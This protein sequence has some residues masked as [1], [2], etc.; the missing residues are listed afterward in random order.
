MS[1][2]SLFGGTHNGQTLS[3][4]SLAL[5]D[6]FLTDTVGG[7]T[8]TE[9]IGGSTYV[10]GTGSHGETQGGILPTS[11]AINGTITDGVLHLTLNL[12]NNTGLVF[13]GMDNATPDTAGSFLHSVV[14]SYHPSGAQKAS[15]D[16]AVNQLVD[17]LKAQGIT[18]VV[19]RVF[20]FMSGAGNGTLA[21]GADGALGAASSDIVL[22]AS[23]NP[24]VQAFAVDLLHAAGA[25]VLKGVQQALVAN[26][27]TIRVEGNTPIHLVGDMNA[28]DITGG[29]GNDTLVGGGGN[30]TLTG[31]LGNDVFGFSALGHVTIKDFDVAHD[32]VAFSS[33]GI[34]NIQQL[35]HLVTSVDNA[36]TGVTFNFG[37]DASITLVGVSASQIT[38]DLIKFTF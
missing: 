7:S 21:A 1:A 27:G 19:F 10:S 8:T 35:A 29:D 26:A 12:P 9:S 16:A 20:D 36:P 14:D 18:N 2:D 31:G 11:G 37:H 15:L 32:T 38:S 13:E 28:Q 34:T 5:L 24:G 33:T 17:S 3:S 25:V 23:Q 22:D 6:Q 30:D 4:S